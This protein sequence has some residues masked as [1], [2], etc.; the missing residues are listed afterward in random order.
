MADVTP[1]KRSNQLGVLYVSVAPRKLPPGAGFTE[2]ETACNA[3]THGKVPRERSPPTHQP[4]PFRGETF[5]LLKQ[6]PK[7]AHSLKSMALATTT[8]QN[9]RVSSIHVLMRALIRPFRA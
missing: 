6:K 1:L 5:N 2:A 4:L 3:E 9:K 8:E 7:I